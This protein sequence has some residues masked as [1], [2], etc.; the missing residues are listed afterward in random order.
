[1][2][3]K[4]YIL[5]IASLLVAVSLSFLTPTKAQ[6]PA[7]YKIIIHS[8]NS[9]N[10]ISKSNLAK[11]FLK[12]A[13]KWQDG[14]TVQPVDQKTSTSVRQVFSKE[15]LNRTVSAVKAYWQQKIFSGLDVPPPQKSSDAAVINYVSNNK[16]AVGYVSGSAQIGN[17]KVLNIY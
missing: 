3:N 12:K 11:L 5:V 13:K 17:T 1:M 8:S 16:G 15:I 14:S 4:F 7:P 6:S 9:T 2:K 10:S